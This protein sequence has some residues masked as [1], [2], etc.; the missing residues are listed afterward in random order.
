MGRARAK[1]KIGEKILISKNPELSIRK[2]SAKS[3][4]LKMAGTVQEVRVSR[5]GSVRVKS[6]N[7]NF[8]TFVDKDFKILKENKIKQ[9]PTIF[10]PDNLM[11]QEKQ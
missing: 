6:S 1:A 9:K 11:S 2:Y 10:D 5:I 7:G 3:A 4:K 8:L